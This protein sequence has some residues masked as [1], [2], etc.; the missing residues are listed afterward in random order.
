MEAPHHLPRD[1]VEGA[2]VS[3]RGV[4]GFSGPR[5][6]DEQVAKTRPGEFQPIDPKPNSMMDFGSRPRPWRRS[7]L[8]FTPNDVISLPVRASRAC[9]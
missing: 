5:S 1:N 3:R 7:V 9:R 4:I 2:D 6:D 8:P